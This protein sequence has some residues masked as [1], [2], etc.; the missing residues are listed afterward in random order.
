MRKEVVGFNLACCEY[1]NTKRQ[2]RVDTIVVR[3]G[4]FGGSQKERAVMTKKLDQEGP[5]SQ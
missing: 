4:F 2:R 1:E 3:A 5:G